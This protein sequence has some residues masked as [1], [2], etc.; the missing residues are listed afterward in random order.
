MNRRDFLRSA[1]IAGATFR[2][3]RATQEPAESAVEQVLVMF[4]C[5]FDLG[6]IDTQAGVMRKYF[7]NYFPLAIRRANE[8]R[9]AGENHYIWTT[10]SWLLY[11]YLEQAG[12]AE[13]KQ[14]D[15]AIARG[16]IAWHA[17]P[18]S[19]QT[20]LMDAS[21]IAA[22]IGFSKSLD[23]RFGRNTTGA[24]MTDVP[25]H[26]R[27]LITP[28]IENGV[29]FLDI[30]VNSA[31]TPPQV[32]SVFN[33]EDAEDGD[34]LVMMYHYREYGGVVLI[35]GSKIAVSVNV[36]NDNSGPHTPE[37]IN[38][39]YAELRKRFP[40]AQIRAANLTD[41]A[42]AVVPYRGGL[43]AVREEIGDTW[44]Y[45][46]AS[47]PVKVARLREILR[48]R[49]EWIAQG[50]FG[51]GS[52]V[53]L[54][55]MRR[56]S[57][58]VEHTWGTDTKTWLDFDH[59]TPHDLAQMLDKPNYRTVM[60]SWQEKRDDIDQGVAALPPALR[61]T[62]AKRLQALKPT[63]P[64]VAGWQGHAPDEPLET[65]HFTVAVD[66]ASGALRTLRSKAS[67][68][69]WASPDH[70]LGLF[71]YQTLSKGDY[72]RFLDS[73]VKSKADWAPKDFGKPGIEKFG[74][75]SRT[76][77]PQILHGWSARDEQGCQIVMQLGFSDASAS[78]LKLTAWPEKVYVELSFPNEKPSVK[79][80]LSWL[81]KQ[82]NRLPEALWLTFQ[83]NAPETRNWVL[84]KADR[85]ISAFDVVRGGNRH[86]HA[87]SDG[88]RYGDAH[89]NLQIQSLDAPLLA[90]GV[91]S[92]IYFS[93]DQPDINNGIHFCLFNNG[94]GT[95]YIQWF[96]EDMRFRFIL[97]AT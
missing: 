39:I 77:V 10:G 24:K 3:L 91:R 25:G 18:F 35:P 55:L 83:P 28:L 48:L 36:R 29:T 69:D 11:E 40:K 7:D 43:P 62:A 68:R 22:T 50:K 12:T 41:I 33:W 37:E 88:L 84:N 20:E 15:A 17:L 96:G 14:M 89:G 57:L 53:D 58:A 85:E 6:F 94:W 5:H 42:N 95:N 70:P 76:W 1:A 34:S 80:N 2:E 67:G 26:T 61:Q 78:A 23:R 73:Y 75:Q 16:D 71:V 52:E 38:A 44:I 64:P 63:P 46:V 21:M 47:D 9:G 54:A 82:A 30:G 56:F 19:W 45:G 79:L 65:K 74:A 97:N 66:P 87:V 81:G 92:P 51:V 86:M 59:Y 4:K 93:N 32:P 13:R 8:M 31:S 60:H 90:L 72:D 27:G 49:R